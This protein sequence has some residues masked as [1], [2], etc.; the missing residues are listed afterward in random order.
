MVGDDIMMTTLYFHAIILLLFN[1]SGDVL[2]IDT[3]YYA[4]FTTP[5]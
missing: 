3:T 5:E 2:R 4:L 1:V